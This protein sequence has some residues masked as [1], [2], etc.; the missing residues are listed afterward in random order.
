MKKKQ[1]RE[2]CEAVIPIKQEGQKSHTD[3][4]KFPKF[5]E[6]LHIVDDMSRFWSP[7]IFFAQRPESLLIP[8]AKHP[9]RRAQKRIEGSAY[10]LQAAQRLVYSFMVDTIHTRIWDSPHFDSDAP[11][12]NDVVDIAG[13]EIFQSTGQ[14]TFG[15]VCQV[16]L[17]SQ[18]QNEIHWDT[19]THTDL[20]TLPCGLIDFLFNSYTRLQ[21]ITFVPNANE[22]CIRF[23]A[24]HAISPTVP[25]MTE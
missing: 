9:G 3:A 14:A 22:M 16:K 10:E 7:V 15:C 8:A 24:I 6:L 17:G 2:T 18:Y 19:R 4:W 1:T 5:H 25:C 21:T 23:D 12:R 13:D 11:D 20:L